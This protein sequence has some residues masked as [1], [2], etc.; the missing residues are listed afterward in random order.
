M[1]KRGH[2]GKAGVRLTPQEIWQRRVAAR[3]KLERNKIDREV[4]DEV[5][6]KLWRAGLVRPA[7]ITFA[8]D[9]MGLYGPQV[10]KDCLAEEPDVDM[11]E[12]G[13]LY[14]RWDQL[15]AL[16]NLTRRTPRWFM[17]WRND[18][19]FEATTLRFHVPDVDQP[20]LIWTYPRDVVRRTVG[21]GL[22]LEDENA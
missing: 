11:W 18:V 22:Y 12:A 9:A 13:V 14:P 20:P 1:T 6:H 19:P 17:S 21:G 16:A 8:L 4:D 15:V 10:D 3:V 2:W 7:A 5:A